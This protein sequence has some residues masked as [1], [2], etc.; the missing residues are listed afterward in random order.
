MKNVADLIAAIA[1]GKG[2]KFASF[3]YV[4]KE[5]GE[6]ARH[7][8]IL[9]A[10]TEVLY[11]KDVAVLEQ[12]VPDLTGLS[13]EAAEAILKSRRTSLKV[14][15][16]NNP[17]YTCAGVYV[18]PDGLAGVKVH[19]VDGSICIDGLQESKVVLVKGVYKTVNSKPLTL[20]KKEIS[21]SLPSNRFRQFRLDRVLEAKMN[22]DVLEIKTEA[23]LIDG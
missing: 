11:E 8:L 13:L 2:A 22:G 10:S 16:G 5:T 14:G 18:Y 6:K 9:G 20:A 17:D 7:T 1:K 21:K 15:I 4:A 12:M 19:V 3:T 23:D